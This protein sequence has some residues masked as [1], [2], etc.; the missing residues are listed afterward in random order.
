MVGRGELRKD[1]SSGWLDSL[2]GAAKEVNSHGRRAHGNYFYYVE[3]TSTNS[4]PFFLIKSIS[5]EHSTTAWTR[6]QCS[7]TKGNNIRSQPSSPYQ[8]YPVLK[9]SHNKAWSTFM[10][11]KYDCWKFYQHI[12]EQTF[13]C[14]AW[15]VEQ[16]RLMVEQLKREAQVTRISVSQVCSFVKITR[17]FKAFLIHHR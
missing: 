8:K 12:I 9:C 7:P 11:S 6:K 17:C 4:H 2:S 1:L 3:D 10:I 13:P 15:K 14:F 16:Q 5:G